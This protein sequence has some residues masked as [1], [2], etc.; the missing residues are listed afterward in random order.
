MYVVQ[1]PCWPSQ[2]PVMPVLRP[3]EPRARRAEEGMWLR[4]KE[5]PNLFLKKVLAGR[6]ALCPA[7]SPEMKAVYKR[8]QILDHALKMFFKLRDNLP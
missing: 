6:T 8:C 2:F 3:C 5:R 7:D 1:V 4:A